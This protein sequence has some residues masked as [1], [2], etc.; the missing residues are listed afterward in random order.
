MHSGTPFFI[1][2]RGGGGEFSKFSKKKGVGECSD[3]SHKKGGVGKMGGLF[4]KKEGGGY[5][6]FSLFLYQLTLSSVVF[7]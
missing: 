1:K 2:R 5:Y 6:L 4:Y 3:F 7:L